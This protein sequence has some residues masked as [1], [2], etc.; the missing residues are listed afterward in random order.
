MLSEVMYCLVKLLNMCERLTYKYLVVP[1]VN[2]L[3]GKIE[4]ALGKT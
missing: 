3:A 4:L 2:R 1:K